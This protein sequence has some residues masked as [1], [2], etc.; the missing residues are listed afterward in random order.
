MKFLP[1]EIEALRHPRRDRSGTVVHTWSSRHA[2]A[3]RSA[4]VGVGHAAR[5][6]ARLADLDS[7]LEGARAA[8]EQLAVATV[9]RLP[10]R[11]AAT[12]LLVNGSI[13]RRT[14]RQSTARARA[15]GQALAIFDHLGAPFG[16]GR[17]AAAL[18]GHR[19]HTRRPLTETERR[20]TALVVRAETDREVAAA[21]FVTENTV[22]PRRPGTSSREARGQVPRP[23]GAH[24][25]LRLGR[26]RGGFPIGINVLT[27][28]QQ[29]P[30]RNHP[31]SH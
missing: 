12:A 10:I 9:Q 18:R 3:S 7:D 14:R 15:F 13:E 17:P 28:C 8:C 31:E 1:D 23:N 29:P 20:V 21:I 30:P 19:A 2:K 5:C 26:R 16:P 24:G 27:R 11:R 4:P 22:Q 6:R 25:P